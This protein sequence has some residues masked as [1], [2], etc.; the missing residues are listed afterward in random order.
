MSTAPRLAPVKSRPAPRTPD[1]LGAELVDRLHARDVDGL[2]ALYEPS[3]VLELPDGSVATGHDEIRAFYER[4]LSRHAAVRAGVQRRP[5][6]Q[7]DLALTTTVLPRSAG[8]GGATCEVARRQPDGTW[9]WIIDR[10]SVR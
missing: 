6:V 9:R 10:P 3:A 8:A 7:G 1:A 4:T 5:L 2:V